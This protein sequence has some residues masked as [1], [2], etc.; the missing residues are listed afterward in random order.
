MRVEE[1]GFSIQSWLSAVA[2]MVL[3]TKKQVK[4]ARERLKLCLIKRLLT[5][6]SAISTEKTVFVRYSLGAKLVGRA[7]RCRWLIANLI[8]WAIRVG[9]TRLMISGGGRSDGGVAE[10]FNEKVVVKNID[11]VITVKIGRRIGCW[12]INKL[13]NKDR[14][15]EDING[16]VVV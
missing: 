2:K 13:F 7:G 6:G 15:V 8:G 1:V 10:V 5:T 3:G 12:G 14:I 11:I 16:T 9:V 4:I